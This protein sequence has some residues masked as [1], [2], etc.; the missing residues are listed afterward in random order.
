MDTMDAVDAIHAMN[1]I[2]AIDASLWI[3]AEI[4]LQAIAPMIISPDT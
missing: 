1:T 3:D 4:Y 2:D